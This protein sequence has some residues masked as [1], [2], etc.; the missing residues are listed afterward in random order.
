[1]VVKYLKPASLEEAERELAADPRARILAGGTQIL[2]SEYRDREIA[3]VDVLDLL[4][5]GIEREEDGTLRV[6][7]AVLF[8]D[9]VDSPLAPDVLKD[10][11]RGMANR[12]VRNAATVGGNL[13]ADKACSSLIPVLLVLDAR[14]RLHGGREPLPLADWLAAPKGIVTYVEIP[15]AP[16]LR[17]AYAR[18]SRTACDLSLLSCAVTYRLAD[19]TVRDLRIACGG[20]DS[21]SRR[22]P[23]LE[24]LFEDKPLPEREEAVTAISPLLRPR[25]DARGS[26][27]FKRLR[28]AE[29]VADSLLGAG[30]EAL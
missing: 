16:G 24:G 22:F 19:G 30:E 11:A 20:L 7:A 21:R 4:P 9:L 29:L 13:G 23:E 25:D 15:E 5:R 2:S 18:W 17:G 28:A 6:G 12:N 8:Q 27:A 1:V 10:A 14:V 26:A 3:A